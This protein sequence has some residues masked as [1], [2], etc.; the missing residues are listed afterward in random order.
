MENRIN[1]T[2]ESKPTNS[3]TE[4]PNSS[5]VFN[6]TNSSYNP[7][8]QNPPNNQFNPLPKSPFGFDNKSLSGSGSPSLGG[9]IPFPANPTPK[10]EEKNGLENI[11]PGGSTSSQKPENNLGINFDSG[12]KTD[13]SLIQDIKKEEID[14]RPRGSKSTF[15]IVL[16]AIIISAVA[17]GAGVWFWL[18]NQ[19]SNLNQQNVLLQ[20]KLDNLQSEKN[21]LEKKLIEQT[22]PNNPAVL[23]VNENINS[24]SN[25]N[26]IS[27]FSSTD[28]G[29]SSTITGGETDKVAFTVNLE[30]C[31]IAAKN[32]SLTKAKKYS[33]L[34]D[35]K[36]DTIVCGYLQPKKENLFG[37]EQNIAYF[38]VLEFADKDFQ[39]NIKKDDKD[40]YLNLGCLNDGVLTGEKRE[41]IS[42]TGDYVDAAT[43]KELLISTETKPVALMLS[44]GFHSSGGQCSCCNLTHQIRVVEK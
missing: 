24:N 44:F 15:I 19:G 22:T 14:Q 1:F 34:G 25:D 37:K 41:D 27:D 10:L 32:M 42:L 33:M 18:S 26:S 21:V 43:E 40:V 39:T 3:S 8:S 2:P 29:S 30:K 6:S 16:L 12:T 38:K 7:V 4:K 5:G 13:S 28:K 17:G 11:L 35:D 36:F 9:G 23:P 20:T 31:N